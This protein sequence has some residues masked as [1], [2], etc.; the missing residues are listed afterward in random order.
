MTRFLGAGYIASVLKFITLLHPQ[1]YPN[2][3]IGFRYVVFFGGELHIG[4]WRRNCSTAPELK[5]FVPG[6][7]IHLRGGRFAHPFGGG[8][9]MQCVS[10]ED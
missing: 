1:R 5:V 4:S 3:L 10:A 2:V 9:P 6:L 7:E 8:E